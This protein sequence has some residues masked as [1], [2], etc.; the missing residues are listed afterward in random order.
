[1]KGNKISWQNLDEADKQDFA[2]KTY[3]SKRLPVFVVAWLILIFEAF[4]MVSV[5]I[6]P[7]VV[8]QSTS[9]LTFFLL[10]TSLFAVTLVCLI[11]MITSRKRFEQ[12]PLHFLNAC[13][14]FAFFICYWSSYLS[15]F[16]HRSTVEISVY[17][18]TSLFVSI[19]VPMRPWHALLLYSSNWVFF[20][21][22]LQRFIDPALDPFSSQLNSAFAAG[23]CACIAIFWQRMRIEDFV[24]TKTILEQNE[25][26]QRMNARLNAMITLDALTQIHNRRFMDKEFP[27]LLSEARRQH[28]PVAML[29]LD[30][31]HFKQYNDHYGHQSGDECLQK[32][33]R[34]ISGLLPTKNG[35]FVR[36][37][38]EEFLLLL[39]DIQP[40][41]ARAFAESVR[42]GIE[43]ACL[44]HEASPLG[45]VTLSVGVCCSRPNGE[46]TIG[47]L[48][49]YVD[50]AMYDAKS[51][52]R[53]RVS[54]FRYSGKD[55][56]S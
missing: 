36:Y 38:G 29:M 37:G 42:Y 48:I 22:M 18:Y 46:S 21:I 11:Y 24:N 10:Y 40:E 51:M 35:Y 54:V 3:H 25:Q 16:T 47:Q 44:P 56:P 1:M 8:T 12:K 41:D 5:L 19:L 43:Q 45:Y 53:N 17:L 30:V 20:M 27:L 28:Q 33:T 50:A 31:D 34:I 49:Q 23:L 15:A 6:Q 52:G 14:L 13:L 55:A 26:I 7:G 32:V 39:I 9:R 2:V 4:M